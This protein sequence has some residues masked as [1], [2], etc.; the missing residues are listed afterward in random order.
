MLG[1][2]TPYDLRSLRALTALTLLASAGTYLV[3]P[4]LAIYLVSEGH[5]SPGTAGTVI[6]VSFLGGRLLSPGAN[7]WV[8]LGTRDQLLLGVLASGV[9]YGLLAWPGSVSWIAVLLLVNSVGNT[10]FQAVSKAL[11]TAAAADRVAHWFAWRNVAFNLGA[12]IG[13]GA[14]ALLVGT[15]GLRTL[16]LLAAVCYAAVLPLP[17]VA[18]TSAADRN[19]H[20]DSASRQPA[21]GR[22]GLATLLARD[23]ALRALVLWNILF[24]SLNTQINITVPLALQSV[25]RQ[26]WIGIVFPASAVLTVATQ[27][28]LSRLME[29]IMPNAQRQL[30]TGMVLGAAGLLTLTALGPLPHAA[31]ATFVVTFTLGEM[32]TVTALDTATGLLSGERATANFGITALALAVGRS[33]GTLMGGWVYQAVPGAAAWCL[34]AAAG[35]ASTLLLAW[36]D[37]RRAHAAASL[38]APKGCPVTAA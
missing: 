18:A 34:L 11:L 26:S 21:T 15:T 36:S 32:L 8:H 25:G 37:H 1:P 27:M 13:A 7:G 24:W 10:F 16:L 5:L 35:T 29:R 9:S 28:P 4:Y 20:R 6:A 30:T 33:L 38:T 31:A 19:P 12:G 22:S 14:A 23:P 17:F 3:T 2:A